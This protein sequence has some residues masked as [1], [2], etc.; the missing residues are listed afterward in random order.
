M[1]IKAYTLFTP[2]HKEL[3]YD[4]LL[5][6]FIYNPNIELTIINKPQLCT[7]AEFGTD[8]W[9]D[10]MRYKADCFYEKIKECNEENELFMF[11]DPDIVIYKDFYNDIIER[12]KGYDVLFQN[13]YGGGVNTGFFIARNNKTVRSFFNTVRGNLNNFLEEQRTTNFFLRNLNQYPSIKIKWNMLPREY[14][15]YGEIASQVNPQ[16][17]NL[18]SNWDGIDESFEIPENIIIHHGNW[19]LKKD[20]KNKILDLVKKKVYGN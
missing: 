10:T 2:S 1:K 17:N 12:I 20:D 18:K 3:L 5:N 13:D 15:N 4:Y 7:T 14:W 19:T 11:I 9:H 8:G 6:S 16:T